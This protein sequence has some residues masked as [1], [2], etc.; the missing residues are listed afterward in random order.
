MSLDSL[1]ACR[2]VIITC[3]TGGVGKTTLSSA[4][5]IRAALNGRKTMVVTMD[6]AK[7][8]ATSL[9]F[10]GLGDHATDLTPHL[11]EIASKRGMNFGSGKLSAMMPDTR[12]TLEG[13]FRSLAPTPGIADQLIANPIFQ[14]FSKEFSGANEY[15]ALER[16]DT[17]VT[18]G[19]YDCVILD[20]PPSRN[21]LSFLRAPQLLGR[22]FDEGFIKWLVLPANKLL[23]IGMQKTLGVLEKLTGDGF[24]THL[25]EFAQGLLALQASF[26]AKIQRISALLASEE[27]GFV[28]VAGPAS[29]T[30]PD[31]EHFLKAISQNKL[32]FD[33]LI[34]NRSMAS[35]EV[36]DGEMASAKP[37]LKKG[38]ELLKN[39]EGRENRTTLRLVQAIQ[40]E[41]SQSSAKNAFCYRVPELTRD[42]HSMEDLFHVALALD[43]SPLLERVS[44]E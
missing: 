40:S 29:E 4:L 43:R 34:L 13:L 37:D 11:Q 16:L 35:L 8:L 42:V 24:I 33:G 25:L 1:F 23:S 32:Q 36:G 10:E 20:T 14:M 22:L 18:A 12:R 2:K 9:G 30:L 3:G 17:L 19:I 31:L 44:G 5:G 41:V 6:P 27:V 21:T 26:T 39:L 38:L 15:M 7:R 28:M